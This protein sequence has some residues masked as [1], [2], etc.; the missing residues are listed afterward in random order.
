M[1]GMEIRESGFREVNMTVT[2]AIWILL[3]IAGM[4]CMLYA[5]SRK[6][7]V[8][9]DHAGS[10]LGEMAEGLPG[11]EDFA[12]QGSLLF[13]ES[14]SAQLS[15]I[16][17]P[18]E[19]KI[20][21]EDVTV[22][23]RYRD[24]ELWIYIQGAGADFYKQNQIYGDVSPIL[25]GKVQMKR[26]GIVLKMQMKRVME[27]YTTMED[28][29]MTITFK[30]P[31]DAYRYVAVI[32]PMGGGAEMGYILRGYAE[33]ALALQIANLLPDCLQRSD[34]KLYFTRTEDVEVSREERLALVD[35]VDADFYVRICAGIDEDASRYGVSAAYN[36]EYFIP[37]PG[38]VELADALAR[39]V[40]TASGNR[41]LGLFAAD[42]DSILQDVKVAAAQINVGH[43]TN[44]AEGELLGWAE[45]RQ[46][47][48][49]G[50]ADAVMEVCPNE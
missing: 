28:N 36:E 33:K 44:P 1:I 30:N 12:E 42:M 11:D 15:A 7:I 39:S 19:K 20:Q 10:G 34:I 29:L 31:H 4:S 26:G 24:K 37:K 6:A 13:Q 22:E 40:A 50:I 18:L 46:K 5:A 48:A 25:S 45:Y 27:Y 32:D 43:L 17:I 3:S 38:N 23:N 49:Q 35:A 21:A 16:Y 2:L 8:I 47:L 9:M 14:E 41:A